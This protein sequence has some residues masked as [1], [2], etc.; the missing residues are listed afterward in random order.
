MKACLRVF[1][2]A[3]LYNTGWAR[4]WRVHEGRDDYFAHLCLI[5][6][7]GLPANRVSRS[8]HPFVLLVPNRPRHTDSTT[9]KR[10]PRDLP[11]LNRGMKPFVQL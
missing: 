8:A 3:V 5:S 11:P 2:G 6:D 7:A 9:T 10:R 4:S 1:L